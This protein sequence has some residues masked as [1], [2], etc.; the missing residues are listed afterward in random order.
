MLDVDHVEEI[1]KDSQPD[2]RLLLPDS[3]SGF[4]AKRGPMPPVSNDQRRFPR[5]YYPASALLYGEQLLPA[6]P[7]DIGRPVIMTKDI[8]RT[9]VS[10]LHT[11]QLYPGEVLRLQLPCAE[12][13]L[14]VVRC[15]QRAEACFEVAGFFV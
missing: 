10:L 11:S 5:F 6:F 12:K 7:R 2:H 9:G 4:L 8:S 1:L 14:I 15:Q 13:K 3:L